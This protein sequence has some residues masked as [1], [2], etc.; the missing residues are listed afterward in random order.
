VTVRRDMAKM[1]SATTATKSQVVYVD[2]TGDTIS[3]TSHVP[4][5]LPGGK[6]GTRMEQIHIDASGWED[7]LPTLRQALAQNRR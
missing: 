2:R 1:D 4:S 3:I 7:L 6:W 5:K